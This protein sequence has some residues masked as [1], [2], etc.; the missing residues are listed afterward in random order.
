VPPSKPELR[1]E[2]KR[3]L[4]ALP[5][6]SFRQEGDRA[7]KLLAGHPLWGEYDSLLL[8]LSIKNE[9]D[10]APLLT[11][12]L[13]AGKKV[14]APRIEGENLVFYRAASPSGPWQEG[15]LGI[16]EPAP[17]EALA[18]ADFPALIIVPG[19]AFDRRGNR[20]GRGRGYYDRFLT[21]LANGGLVFKAAGLCMEAQLLP[22]IPM[23]SRDRQ[24]DGVCTGT[25]L[26]LPV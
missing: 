4:A 8:F 15:P 12:A 2:L 9:I 26:Y 18:P 1:R 24:M 7:A 22:E 16:R 3:R 21:A 6:E 10:S 14:F 11:A 5:P 23:D 13:E 20:L 25:A 17:T 19:L